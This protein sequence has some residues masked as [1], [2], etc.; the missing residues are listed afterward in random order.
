M[1]VR[2]DN[3]SL[4]QKALSG[5]SQEAPNQL[6]RL[7]GL[8]II[9]AVLAGC[10][11]GSSSSNSTAPPV[12]DPPIIDPPVTEPPVTEPQAISPPQG[13]TATHSPN[14]VRLEWTAVANITHYSVSRNGEVIAGTVPI[15]SPSVTPITYTDD[16]VA[17]GNNYTYAVRACNDAGCSDAR[18]ILVKYRVP[19]TPTGLI[20]AFLPGLIN[21]QWTAVDGITRYQ[22]SRNGTVMTPNVSTTNHTDFTPMLG[23]TYNYEVRVCNIL[24]CSDARSISVKYGVPPA[25]PRLTA[26]LNGINEVNSINLVWRSAVPMIVVYKVSRN[27]IVLADHIPFTKTTYEDTNISIG[28]NY[29]YTVSACNIFGCSKSANRSIQFFVDTDE[30]GEPDH[31]DVDDDGNGLI[32]IYTAEELNATRNNLKGTGLNLTGANSD[33]IGCG[34]AMDADGNIITDEC[35]GYE[36]MANLDLNELP[37]ITSGDF[38]GSNWLPIGD[39]NSDF[40]GNNYNISNLHINSTAVRTGVGL[41]G[42]VASGTSISNV[43]LLNVSINV[44][45]ADKVGGLVGDG[46]SSRIHSSSVIANI[47]TGNNTVGGLVGD[48]ENAKISAS[49]VIANI[50]TGN[51]TVGGLVGDGENAKISASSAGVPTL[52]GRTF[53]GG[54]VGYGESA[55]INSSSAVGDTLSGDNSVGGLVGAAGD[56]FGAGTEGATIISSSTWVITLSGNLN[57]GGLIGFAGTTMINSSLAITTII[58]GHANLGGL[59]GSGSPIVTNSYWDNTA[60]FSPTPAT[61]TEYPGQSD[62]DLK[63]P[64]TFVGIYE[65]WANNYCNPITGEYREITSGSPADGFQQAWLLGEADQYPILNCTASTQ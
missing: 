19:A 57:A 8:L 31:I 59:V 64:T 52:T 44:P 11:G 33:S 32:E 58:M 42:T 10:D 21:I 38:Q 23:I 63:T 53:V 54:L 16:N 61:N 7:F 9:T 1:N 29:N 4:N 49:S 24:G 50:I 18:S 48:G 17:V 46:N 62:T 12:T 60:M 26:T 56:P 55:I 22:I 37:I 47:I 3:K 39:F 15:T 34:G 65:T 41:F 14:N 40:D 20:A 2:D 13:F 28:N 51:N 45:N 25:E 6:A 30:D 5:G 43:H 36:L 35:S 27:G